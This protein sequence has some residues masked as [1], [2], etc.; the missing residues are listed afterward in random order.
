LSSK[1]KLVARLTVGIAVL[2]LVLV[3]AHPSQ[4]TIPWGPSLCLGLLVAVCVIVCA[5]GLSA[6]RWHVI[7]GRGAPSRLYLWRLYLIGSF[8]S[9]FLPT[10]VGGDA[11]R[12]AAA[13]RALGSAGSAVASTLLDRLFGTAALVV[14]FLLGA[15]IVPQLLQPALVNMHW[16]SSLPITLTIVV[17][18]ASLLGVGWLLVRKSLL[19]AM[20]REGGEVVAGL[21]RTPRIGLV[22]FGLALVVQALYILAWGMLSRAMGIHLSW[23]VFLACVPIAS[24]AAL[25]PVT[26]SGLGVREGVWVL[27]LAPLGV[28]A[29]TTVVFSLAYF[30]CLVCVGAL[31]AGAFILWGTAWNPGPRQSSMAVSGTA[32]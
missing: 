20:V 17:G 22:A 19:G 13:G 16:A 32:P 12:A 7:L 18:G 10:S 11:V 31:G 28:P 30:F 2:T 1:L 25:L 9:L 15:A 23:L 14:Y 21:W 6:V 8:F 4:S 24:L 29:S 5:Q 26:I 27:L 3:H